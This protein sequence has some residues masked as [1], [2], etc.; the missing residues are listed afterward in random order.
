MPRNA[1][2]DGH[3]LTRPDN[4]LDRWRELSLSAEYPADAS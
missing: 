3:D 4:E 1:P 2:Q